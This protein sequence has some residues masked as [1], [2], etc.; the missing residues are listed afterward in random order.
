MGDLAHVAAVGLAVVAIGLLLALVFG[1]T[2]RKNSAR[3]H[4]KVARSQRS[5]NTRIEMAAGEAGGSRRHRHR[6]R[7]PPPK[8]D[9]FANREDGAET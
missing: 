2:L 8:I 7:P 1:V 9:L 5:G 3:R 6:K 4:R